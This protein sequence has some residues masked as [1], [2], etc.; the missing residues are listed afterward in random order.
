MMYNK[1]KSKQKRFASEHVKKKQIILFRVLENI[2][3]LVIKNE[4]L[5][6]KEI[7]FKDDCRQEMTRL[8]AEIR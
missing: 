6:Q 3:K 8:Q 1:M 4:E 7:K 5:K 2:Q